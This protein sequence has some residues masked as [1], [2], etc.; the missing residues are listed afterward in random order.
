M[1]A[2]P[3]PS[4]V[5][6]AACLIALGITGFVNGDFALVWQH[7]PAHLPRRSTLAYACAAI[8]VAFGVGLLWQRTLA[9]TCRLL[10]AYMV[11]WL[12]LLEV[13][14]V[15]HAPLDAGAWGS[16]GEI[17]IITA[18]AWCLF[19]THSGNAGVRA[20]R[21]L[22]I[23]ALPMIGAEVI[24]D[25]VKAGDKIMQ[26]WLQVLPDPMAWACFTGVCSIATALALLFGVWP[27]LAATLE[28]F[29]LG[30]I[31]VAYW[32]PALHTGRTA[33]TAF[34]ISFLIAA[35]VWIVADSYRGVRWFGSGRPVWNA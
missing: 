5:F 24:V 21:C 8:E 2:T 34:I 10:F 25:A 33:T 14:G 12:V 18:G 32:A 26:P 22:L 9:W 15:I 4:R 7:V 13:P 27:R 35:G 17:A 19:A 29:M 30:L 20:A 23:V 31:A 1:N 3:Q 11:L 6:F 16:V 28:A